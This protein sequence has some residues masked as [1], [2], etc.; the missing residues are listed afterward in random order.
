MIIRKATE[1]D[2]KTLNE[3]QIALTKYERK[4]AKHLVDPEKVKNE[5][6]KEYKKRIKQKN[7]VFFVAQENDKI[8]GYILG[9]IEKP[10]HHHI[11][12]K[13]G[14]IV[15]AFVIK[16]YRGKGIGEKLTRR[17]LEW[18]KSKGIKWIRVSAYA[19][20]KVGINFWKKMGFK[21]YVVD[22]TKIEE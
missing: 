8:V 11:F 9:E 20:N 10:S 17:L 7:S 21:N 4:I 18:F 6:L 19:N 5:Y 14:Y 3:L 15:D 16:E 12:K 22:M 13:R 1:K 2:L